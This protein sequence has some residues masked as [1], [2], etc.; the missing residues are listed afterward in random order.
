MDTGETG[1]VTIR[2]PRPGD[3]PQLGALHNAVWRATYAGM[4]AAEHLRR[5]DDAVA[6]RHWADV[7]ATLDEAG[8][9][10]TGRVVTVAVTD[11]EV[12]GFLSTGPGRGEDPPTG[13]EIEALYV[14]VRHHGTGVADDLLRATVRGRPAH[15]WVLADNARAISFYRR[16]GFEPDGARST[17]AP[18][19]AETI[20]MTRR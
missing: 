2:A 5:L 19:G 18:T 17:H 11:D 20:R 1:A 7:L 14:S 13:L 8:R 10:P 3:A 15:L 12:I 9:A 6:T 16:H 4:V